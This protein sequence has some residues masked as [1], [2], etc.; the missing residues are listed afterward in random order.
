VA[1][2][3][4][5]PACEARTLQLPGAMSVSVFPLTAQTLDE[6]VEKV[7]ARPELAVALNAIGESRMNLE[8]I[9]GKV[10]VWFVLLTETT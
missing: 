3:A 5:L 1:L 6:L 7:T 9:V 4:A 10:I 8:P 2:Y